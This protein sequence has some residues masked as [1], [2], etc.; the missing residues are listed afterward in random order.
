MVISDDDVQKALDRLRFQAG[1]A[2]KAKAERIYFE[3]FR[4][5]VKA[6]VMQRHL[7]LPVSAQER[8]AY[9]SDE[10]KKHLLVM[11][12]AIEKD[13]ASRWQMVA[14]QAVIEAWRT[15]SANQRGE[16]KIG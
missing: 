12:D 11:R 14:A 10:Y 2:A 8:E 6:N 3:E 15:A 5:T 13:E 7:D 16:G 9:S 4:K 1:A